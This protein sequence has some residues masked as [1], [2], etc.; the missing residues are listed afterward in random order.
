MTKIKNAFIKH[1]LIMWANNNLKSLSERNFL[2]PFFTHIFGPGPANLFKVAND[3]A[4]LFY[5]I[6]IKT[7]GTTDTSL[8]AHIETSQQHKKLMPIRAQEPKSKITPRRILPI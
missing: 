1:S 5:R 8:L 4:L 3:G 2:V 7:I 6:A